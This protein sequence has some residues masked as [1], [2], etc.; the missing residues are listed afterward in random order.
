[1]SSSSPRVTDWIVGYTLSEPCEYTT[2]QNSPSIKLITEF[3]E[4]SKSNHIT[5]FSILITGEHNE[6]EVKR[7]ANQQAKRLADIITFKRQKRVT[8]NLTGLTKKI[9]TDP[10][11]RTTSKILRS[12]Y[13]ILK[14]IEL[15]LTNNVIAQ[16]IEKDEEIN[17]RLHHVS[18]ALG[19][20]ELQLFVTMF[21][22]L[23]QV[24][25]D[26][27]NKNSIPDY[28]KYEA[29][30]NAL[31]HRELDPNRPRGAMTQVKQWYPPPCDFEFT[32]TNEFD[33][34]SEKNLRQLKSEANDLKKHVMF[35]LGNNLL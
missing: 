2:I 9:G 7:K 22:E 1:M 26:D 28:L 5:G 27:K 12:S 19:A 32:P 33:H 34:N 21:I 16:M 13:H 17:H 23:F 18:L 31:S 29:L 20:E 4:K 35:Y 25:E 30:R 10:D 11:R 15:D 24:I 3:N 14:D 6:N 8:P